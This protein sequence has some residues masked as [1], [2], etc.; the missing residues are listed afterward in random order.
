MGL[1]WLSFCDPAK[2]KGEQFLGVALVE[3]DDL[4]SATRRAW[5]EGCNPGGEIA[6]F[7]LPLNKMPNA[8]RVILAKAPHHTLL[9]KAQLDE[10]Q[11]T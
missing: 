7:D 11:L 3:A 5:R 2:P 6:G 1:W 10:Y 9:S 8:R 4:P